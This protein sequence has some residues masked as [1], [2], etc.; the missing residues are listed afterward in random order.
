MK[1]PI[2]RSSATLALIL[3]FVS[4]GNS[5]HPVTQKPG[6]NA[7]TVI[8]QAPHI[9]FEENRGQVKDQ[10]NNPRPDVLFAGSATGLDFH[11]FNNGIS[12]QLS[13]REKRNES[14]TS[15]GAP[16]VVEH[17]Q[18]A[19]MTE[20]YRVDIRWVDAGNACQMITGD[21]AEGYNHY[22]NV[23][24]GT[25]PALYVKSYHSVIYKDLWPG[26][27]LHFFG[28]DGILESDWILQKAE[29][30]KQIAF[31]IT[32]AALS[33]DPEGYLVMHTPLGDIREGQLRCY[34]EGQTVQ[35]KW[36]VLGNRVGFEL[37][38]F[39]PERP[40]RIDP[41]VL[42]WGT[43]YGGIGNDQTVANCAVDG[44]GNVFLAGQTGSGNAI[45]TTGAHQVS[46][47]GGSYDGYL[48]KFDSNGVRQ[49]GTYYGGLGGDNGFCT[50]DRQGNCYL[51]GRT[52]SAA[53]I[54]T[55]SAHQTSIGGNY[56]GYLVR[57]SPGGVR[58]WG[59][60]CGGPADEDVNGCTLDEDG[61]VFLFGRTR[62]LS[63][64]ATP[65][66]H[67]T[68]IQGSSSNTD[69]YLVK[70]D[71]TGARQWGTYY[72]GVGDE[73]GFA[74]ATDLAGNVFLAG[75]ARSTTAIATT[76]SAQSFY[77][78]GWDGFLVKFNNNGVRQ[79]G[80]YKGGGSIDEIHGLATD[81]HGYIFASG[82]T[83]STSQIAAGNVHQDTLGGNTDAFLGK[84]NT[85]GAL[86]W[87]TY[88][89]GNM[90][91]YGYS[92]AVDT[93]GNVY[94][95]GLTVSA[96]GIASPSSHQ[97]F[98]GGLQSDGYVALFNT[99]GGHIWGSYYGGSNNDYINS[100]AAGINGNIYVA[101]N[102]FSGNNI[103][104]PG[105]HQTIPGGGATGSYDAFLARFFNDGT[106]VQP[107][108][109]IGN[110]T[111]CPSVTEIYSVLDDS[112]A[113]SYTWSLPAGW[114]G[115]SATN[116]ISVITGNASGTIS[117]T[118]NNASGSS[119]P[120]VLPVTITPILITAQPITQ[121]I[122]PGGNIQF[123]IGVQNSGVGYHWQSDSGAGFQ[124]LTNTG[125][126][127]GVSTNALAVTN[128]TSAN[129]NQPFLCIVT[130]G[131]CSTTSNIALLV[132][133]SQPGIE[134]KEIAAD[135]RIY[136]N[137]AMD[138]L[139]IETPEH[140]ILANYSMYDFWGKVIMQGSLGSGQKMIDVNHLPQGIY[141]IRLSG[142]TDM[143]FRFIRQ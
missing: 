116:F 103:S 101:G 17:E 92:C 132:I 58:Q 38:H 61:N 102:T 94:M 77:G 27:D 100:C 53:N 25:E 9:T 134:E 63:G 89:G 40:L 71:S 15:E 64:I 62:S 39:D 26:V 10:F 90:N 105:A 13:R 48:V 49:W 14:N 68:T 7:N 6:V 124:N 12:Y 95:A 141:L 122:P 127:Q 121:I 80:T 114:S 36:K 113:T 128:A 93:S 20:I 140:I 91:D 106:P 119:V 139:C 56:D 32:G 86:L 107:S 2:I 60:Y 137:P 135:V 37:S 47:W 41:P 3:F 99:H 22:Y 120:R 87:C 1:Y 72:G 65:G 11:L 31:E 24:E 131:N 54:A 33:I 5:Q 117:L 34:Q 46:M 82:I 138:H 66:A 23:P 76:G 129:H 69:A 142:Q 45:A 84:Y 85:N 97:P 109:I 98:Y 130:T 126:F 29:N 83:S 136:P 35:A 70:F 67:Q 50:A 123:T 79:W 125:Q 110:S 4:A 75:Q 19:G 115:S 55:P 43:Y 18:V 21:V 81:Q 16:S 96:N 8:N 88:F 59:T 57:F 52:A 30:Y 74:C 108:A 42:V 104:T 112:L 118:A 111:P 28:R 78:G 143:S 133:G 73:Y 44:F 51:A